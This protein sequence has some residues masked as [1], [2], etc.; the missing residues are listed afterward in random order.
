MFASTNKGIIIGNNNEDVKDALDLL[1][2]NESVKVVDTRI[3]KEENKKEIKKK[4]KTCINELQ[5]KE[6]QNCYNKLVINSESKE[7]E[8]SKITFSPAVLSSKESLIDNIPQK[9]DTISLK[10]AHITFSQLNQEN[11]TNNLQHLIKKS[12]KIVF[13]N[14]F[15]EQSLYS[16]IVKEV[17]ANENCNV[18]FI[19]TKDQAKKIITK[20]QNNTQVTIKVK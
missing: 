18:K 1:A 5:K 20:Q 17:L 15:I 7:T 6:S 12:K 8:K 2:K 3:D 19:F 14:C 9:T 16:D 10:F 4:N 13:K 11:L